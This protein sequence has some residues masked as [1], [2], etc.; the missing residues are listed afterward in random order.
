M[1]I[2][3]KA[4]TNT[5]KDEVTCGKHE[6]EYVVHVREKPLENRANEKICTLLA[7]YFDVGYNKVRILRGHHASRKMI[8]ILND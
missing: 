2:T 1:I 5:R 8:E 4:T 7:D 3:V 6:G